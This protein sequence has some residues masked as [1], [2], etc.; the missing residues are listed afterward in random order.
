M[1]SP[2]RSGRPTLDAVIFDMDGTLCDVSSVVHHVRGP[3]K[4][5][6]AFHA[7]SAGCPPNGPV[8]AAARRVHTRGR[9]VLVVTGRVAKWAPMTRSW[10]RRH[11]LPCDGLYTR[12]DGDFRPDVVVKAEILAGI[13]REGYQV[14]AAWDDN[15]G[16]LGLWREHGIRV[17]EVPGW[18]GA[19][20]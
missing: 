5:F 10:L 7:G 20:R 18:D 2:G 3:V 15:P 13:G 4:D 6:D 17:V 14:V 11:G 1:P 8:A 12:A 16:V 19:G 9:A